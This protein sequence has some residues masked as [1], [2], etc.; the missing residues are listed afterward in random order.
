MLIGRG[1]PFLHGSP[2]ESVN[3]SARLAVCSPLWFFR[4]M[5]IWIFL[6]LG[7]LA[8]CTGSQTPQSGKQ[9][10]GAA[11]AGAKGCTACHS[12]NGQPGVG[13]SFKGLYGKQE[14]LTDGTTVIV[15][16]AYLTESIKTP[17]A[18]VVRGYTPAM[19]ALPLTDE[20]LAGLITFIKSLK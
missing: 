10:P 16:D 14:T 13:P 6:A 20:E 7:F 19:P 3:K 4:Q 9:D 17:L 15:D 12:L 18:K 8:G 5:R 11:L 2:R 1:T